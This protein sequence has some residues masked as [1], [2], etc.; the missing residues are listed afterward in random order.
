M[1]RRYVILGSAAAAAA[2]AS[3]SGG[4]NSSPTPTPTPTAS[5]SAT[6]TPTPTA[7]YTAFPLAAAAEFSTLNATTNY[8]GDPAAGAVT[9][10]VTATETFTSRVKLAATTD[11]TN[12]TFVM[13]EATEESRFVGTNVT[14]PAAPTV[15][16]FVYRSVST[17]TGAA[18]GNFSQLEV[19]N[20]IGA[21]TVT[22]SDSLLKTLTVLSYA[23][24]WRGDSTTGQKRLTYAIW[25]Y[26]TL[27]YDMLTTGTAN[28][29]ARIVGRSVSVANGATTLVRVGGTATVAVNFAT[30]LVTTTMN[31]TTLPSGGA[32]TTYVTLNAQGAIPIG[33]NQFSGSLVSGGAATGT[34]A[35]AF[36]G[37]KGVNLGIVFGA[38]GTING[39]DTRIV[40][41]VVGVKQ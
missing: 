38:S 21:A 6:P 41:E 1:I 7:T 30:G 19:L 11:L 5:G 18:A 2:L 15:T 26:P 13:D 17:A 25:G 35:G 12:G 24:W 37:S 3:C 9:L 14:T 22:T 40:G 31:L 28:Y 20:N 33:Q 16:E 32:E 10:G 23:N 8:T 36:Y 27:S 4:G 39:A 34:I 29:T